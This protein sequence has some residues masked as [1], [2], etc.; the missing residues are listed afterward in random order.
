MVYER[1]KKMKHKGK[2]TIYM[3]VYVCLY[4]YRHTYIQRRKEPHNQ[5][6]S[7][8]REDTASNNTEVHSL[9]T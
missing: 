6:F 1:E 7:G 4:E 8:F 9:V 3:Y 5:R 2:N